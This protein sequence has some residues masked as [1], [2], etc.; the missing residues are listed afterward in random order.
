[1]KID[2]VIINNFRNYIGLHTFDLTKKVTILYGANGFGKSSFFDAIEWCLTG[3]ISRYKKDGFSPRDVLNHSQHNVDRECGVQIQFGDNQLIRSFQYTDGKVGNIM[4]KIITKDKEII[5]GQDKI[6][7]FLKNHYFRKGKERKGWFGELIRQSYVLSQDQITEFIS[8]E[9]PKER[10]ESLADIMGLKNIMYLFGN[11]RGAQRELEKRIEAEEKEID[12]LKEIMENRKRDL[13]PVDQKEFKSILK[14]L[15]FNEKDEISISILE[16]LKKASL[17][18]VIDIENVIKFND[19][20]SGKGFQQV[21]DIRR[22][23]ET[24]QKQ[25]EEL[26]EKKQ[27]ISKLLEK[28]KK[29]KKTIEEEQ[30]YINKLDS[31]SKLLDSKNEEIKKIGYSKDIHLKDLEEEI[32][33]LRE[34]Q[35]TLSFAITHQ[36]DYKEMSSFLAN[37]KMNREKSITKLNFYKKRLKRIDKVLNDINMYTAGINKK[38]LVDLIE[39][40]QYIEKYSIHSEDDGKCPVCSSDHGSNLP[41]KIQQNISRYTRK[42][43]QDSK[44]ISELLFKKEKFEKRKENTVRNIK[45]LSKGIE[46]QDLR[47]KN[48][49]YQYNLIVENKLFNIDLFVKKDKG[50]NDSENEKVNVQIQVLNNVIMI[51][52]DVKKLENRQKVILN[53]LGLQ[54]MFSVRKLE[55]QRISRLERA[56]KRVGNYYQKIDSLVTEKEKY[57]AGIY[58]VVLKINSLNLKGSLD[59]LTQQIYEVEKRINLM[60]SLTEF[61]RKSEF[62]S[63]VLNDVQ[64]YSPKI[65]ERKNQITKYKGLIFSIQEFI[66]E[67]GRVLGEESEGFLN[68]PRSLIQKYYRYLNPMPHKN[69][70]KFE[71][72][73]GELNIMIPVDSDNSIVKSANHT[74][75]SGQLNVLAISIFLAINQSQKVSQLDFVA[76]D[77]PIQNMDD[78]N[79]YAICDVLSSLDKQLLLSTHDMDFVKLFI[80]KNEYRK[81]DIQLFILESPVLINE[82]IKCVQF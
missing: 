78:V 51:L 21:E 44:R 73:N 55:P 72:N 57:Y 5:K 67:V 12:K 41:V 53:I 1:M 59:Q 25:I 49:L 24:T 60:D 66:K 47:Y 37:Y 2:K 52:G 29:L 4:T 20:L 9:D 17:K 76:I 46:E 7:D 18:K 15:D 58:D 65:I 27:N 70:V 36:Q 62:N 28:I 40:I 10:F 34:Y 32:N 30:E 63:R 56:Y 16:D 48:N 42:L 54:E 75:S 19:S 50:F 71:G 74:L 43:E 22:E 3:Q 39:S 77:D 82:K 68:N 61:K 31:V 26:N 6:E 79:R 45:M 33:R 11:F 35:G 38:E 14:S 8:K 80:K 23:I 13:I 81:N 64:G 69:S